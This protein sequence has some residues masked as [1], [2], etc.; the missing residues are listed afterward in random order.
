MDVKEFFPG[1]GAA[2]GGITRHHGGKRSEGHAVSREAGGDEL[3]FRQFPHEGQAIV[4]FN[5]LAGPFVFD[6]GGGK[7][8]TQHRLQLAVNGPGIRHLSGLVILSAE[9]D[10]IMA[11]LRVGAQIIRIGRVPKE[12]IG[13]GTFGNAGAEGVTGI[14]RQLALKQRRAR[15][16]VLSHQRHM[17][18]DHDVAAF[19]R[20]L[21]DLHLQRLIQNLLDFRMFKDVTAP[22]WNFG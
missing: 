22:T 19:N 20:M 1:I 3:A 17:G 10:A 12:R 16:T 13:H 11:A 6:F 2:Q 4:G 7:E 21:A 9:D 15:Q 8:G 18:G 5:D 14:R